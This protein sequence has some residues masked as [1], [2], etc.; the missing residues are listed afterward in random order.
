[1]EG[2]GGPVEVRV[3]G[4]LGV[5][6]AALEDGEEGQRVDGDSRACGGLG[7]EVDVLEAVLEGEAAGPVVAAAH[8]SAVA[9]G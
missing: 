3:A 9:C 8:T 7:E 2:D 6:E 4:G 1:L 5:L